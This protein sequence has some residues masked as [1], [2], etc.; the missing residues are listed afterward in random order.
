MGLS[1][2]TV[3][4]RWWSFLGLIFLL[5]FLSVVFGLSMVLMVALVSIVFKFELAGF[6][7]VL[8]ICHE[9]DDAY[10]FY[11]LH[12]GLC[13]PLRPAVERVL[14]CFL[15]YNQVLCRYPPPRIRLIQTL[16]ISGKWP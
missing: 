7:I 14:I 3:Q 16:P 12:R 9:A 11:C 15:T 2:R 4:R 1:R 13:R 6:S 5:V 8:L 10:L